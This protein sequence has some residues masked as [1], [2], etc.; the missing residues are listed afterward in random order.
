MA[1]RIA[2]PVLDNALCSHFGQ[3][4]SFALFDI[5]ADGTSIVGRQ[6]HTPPHHEPG[7]YPRWLAERQVTVVLAGGMGGKAQDLF[8]DHN[9]QV[10]VGVGVVAPETVVQ[11]HL[12]GHLVPGTNLCDH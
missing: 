7:V 2:V 6:D 4:E 11:S 3:C 9:I 10:V 8:A 12:A 1:I 5:G